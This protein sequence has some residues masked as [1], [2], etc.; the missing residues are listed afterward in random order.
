MVTVLISKMPDPKKMA[1]DLITTNIVLDILSRVLQNRF[2]YVHGGSSEW[3]P[4]SPDLN[5]CDLSCA[6]TSRTKGTI[7]Y[8]SSISTKPCEVY[9]IALLY[10]NT[11][12]R[13]EKTSS[14]FK[15]K[16]KCL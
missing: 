4:L 10:F 13:E 2:L 16:N 5:H 8:A 6:D 3:L 1:Q 7:Q 11:S 15:C 9:K 14:H 12:Y